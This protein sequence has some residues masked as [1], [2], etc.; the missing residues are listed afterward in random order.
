[1]VILMTDR[2]VSGVLLG[3]R[4]LSSDEIISRKPLPHLMINPVHPLWKA[5]VCP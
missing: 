1:M 2:S 5:K 3:E 4:P